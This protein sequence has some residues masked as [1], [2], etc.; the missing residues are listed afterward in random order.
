MTKLLTNK[1]KPCNLAM[2]LFLR[3]YWYSESSAYFDTRNVI[4]TKKQ[5]FPMHSQLLFPKPLITFTATFS[6]TT[7]YIHSYF[8]PRPL[9]FFLWVLC[10]LNYRIFSVKI[11]T[12]KTASIN[13]STEQISECLINLVDCHP[14]PFFPTFGMCKIDLVELVI[15]VIDLSSHSR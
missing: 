5:S 14:L 10:E 15:G 6:Q 7:D 1:K 11:C 4:E 13:I 12:S 2:K 9:I 8:L 3:A